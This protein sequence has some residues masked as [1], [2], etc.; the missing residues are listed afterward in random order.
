MIGSGSKIKL[1][2]TSSATKQSPEEEHRRAIAHH[3]L[4]V[5]LN[6]MNAHI[7]QSSYPGKSSFTAVLLLSILSTYTIT[8]VVEFS[9]LY[10]IIATFV[11]S[12]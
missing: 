11:T 9:H 10:C 1:K 4:K 5:A 2:R 12:L 3:Q 6:T 7:S 8:L